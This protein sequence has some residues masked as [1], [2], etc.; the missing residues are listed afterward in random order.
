M[1]R[2]RGIGKDNCFSICIHCLTSKKLR[3]RGGGIRMKVGRGGGYIRENYETRLDRGKILRWGKHFL[4][5][6]T[7]GGEI[8]FENDPGASC[9]K[10]TVINQ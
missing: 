9:F 2:K 4:L 10:Y 6:I 1:K 7:M 3:P 8:L 5:N